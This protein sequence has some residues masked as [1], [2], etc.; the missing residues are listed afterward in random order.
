VDLLGSNYPPVPS[1]NPHLLP[2]SQ[3]CSISLQLQ[4][5]ATGA[6]VE[7]CRVSCKHLK[8]FVVLL[9]PLS[10]PLVCVCVFSMRMN[11]KLWTLYT[12]G[13]AP[14]TGD[15]SCRKAATYTQENIHIDETR[16]DMHALNG[17][18]THHPSVIAGEGISCLRPR[19]HC[20]RRVKIE[21]CK[22]IILY[23]TSCGHGNKT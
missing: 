3:C 12:V 10:G 11:L 1:C 8:I 2:F 9:L 4:L 23:A 16:I 6:E 19:G 18:R 21:M 20:D 14:L 17:I 7:M 5:K 13:W 22:I 15:Q